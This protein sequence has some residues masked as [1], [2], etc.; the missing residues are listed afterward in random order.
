MSVDESEPTLNN[1][2][3]N[4]CS[5]NSATNSA[6]STSYA[7]NQPMH[8]FGMAQNTMTFTKSTQTTAIEMTSVGT[9]TDE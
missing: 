1:N 5:S 6:A 2:N 9:Q 8:T 3:N 7:F 4:N